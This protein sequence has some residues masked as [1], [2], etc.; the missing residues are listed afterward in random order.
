MD[1]QFVSSDLEAQAQH[2][3]RGTALQ[4]E[5]R[6]RMEKELV[7]RLALGRPL[8]VKLG[9]DPVSEG[10]HLGHLAPLL[11]FKRFQE[12]G[13]KTYLLLGG[14]TA[15]IGD[16]SGQKETRPL[17]SEA[18]VREN[19]ERYLQEV[20]YILDPEKTIIVNNIT[21]FNAMTPSE[22][23]E[24]VV[25]PVTLQQVMGRKYFRYRYEARRPISLH[26]LV[27]PAVQAYDSMVLCAA[28][29]GQEDNPAQYRGVRGNPDAACDVEVGGNDQLF[30]FRL[31]RELMRKFG[32][33]PQVL[34]TTP[35]I[36]GTDG[37]KMS[38]SAGNMI[39][40]A[41]R[42]EVIYR[43]L[44]SIQDELIV[45]YFET[46]TMVPLREVHSIERGLED[47]SLH[48]H[49]IKQRLAKEVVQ[50]LHGEEAAQRAEE[51]YKARIRGQVPPEREVTVPLEMASQPVSAIDLVM[52]AHL[53][54]SRSE[55]K[56]LLRQRSIRLDGQVIGEGQAFE[57]R[58]GMVVQRGQRRD[59]EAVRLRLPTSEAAS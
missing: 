32:L 37:R 12:M 10:L 31:T 18:Q 29:P 49:R 20:F 24:E 28:K 41:D 8:K 26:E 22:F 33:P 21:W 27:Y 13:H 40:V 34:V 25:S 7:E 35:L 9:L 53:A 57:M 46:I 43:R 38:A 16:P 48:P 5:Q 50:M 47:G 11:A 55:A 59:A 23:L 36:R 4:G 14:F 39:R 51:E 45:T 2:L 30:N 19:T 58:D 6:A 1:E 15:R 44:M 42:P 54:G 52:L 3:M 56:R 17:L